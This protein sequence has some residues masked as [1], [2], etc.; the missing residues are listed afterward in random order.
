[1]TPA[2]VDGYQRRQT[3]SEEQIVYDHLLSYVQQGSPS[4]LIEDFR[5]LFIEGRGYKEAQIYSAL[6]K[7]IKSKDAELNF[8]FFFNRCCHILVNRW[9]MQPQLQSIIPEFVSLFENLAPAR[10]GYHNS[11]NRLRQLVK[12]FTQTDQ[13][14]KL[15]RIA[16]VTSAKQT[17][18]NTNSVG[19]LIHRYPYLYDHCL[20]SDDSSQEHQ[21]TVRQIKTQI[22]RRFEVNLSQY[23]TYKVRLAQVACEPSAA[24]EARRIIRPVNNPTLLSDRELNKALKDFVGN[25]EGGSTYKG[26]S[27]SFLAHSF[28]V[29]TF[30]AFKRDLYE[31]LISS[32]EPQY[33]RGQFNKKLYQTLQNTLPQCDHQKPSEFLMLRTS[34]QLLNFLVVENAH[35]PDHYVFIDMVTNMGVTR[36]V[37]LLLK[38]VLVTHKVKPYLEKRFSI[39]FNHYESFTNDG[40]P[41]LVK[42]LENLHIAF[43]IH[44]GKADLSC[45]KQLK[46]N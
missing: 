5:R 43:S 1:M 6:E 36:V 42:A 7:I 26:L 3:T 2:K 13:Y 8:N 40:V 21:Q 27:Q 30:G 19:N 24:T 9:Q 4:Q 16:R 22:E 28:Y 46:V 23:V 14:V 38:V 20:L 25:V 45:L 17:S 15:E 41:W 11:A 44:F 34:S 29:P 39:L 12:S 18:Q 33:A 10:Q 35:Q 37:G 32:I 31:Y